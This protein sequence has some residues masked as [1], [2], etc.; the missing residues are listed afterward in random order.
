[1]ITLIILFAIA[2]ASF[3][4]YWKERESRNRN[5]NSRMYFY[6]TIG[7]IAIVLFGIQFLFGLI[8]YSCV[9]GNISDLK[10]IDKKIEIQLDYRDRVLK[11]LEFEAS[12]YVSFEKD[13]IKSL[14]P[15]TMNFLLMNYPTLNSFK[16][17]NYLMKNIREANATLWQLE[18]D[19]QDMLSYVIFYDSHIIAW[20]PRPE[21]P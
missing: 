5:R 15:E 12:R 8:M 7:V 20:M 14:K 4:L 6:N 3:F 2:V 9:V 19:K 16:G 11:E 10:V 21:Y 17:I 18:Q 13:L 1:M